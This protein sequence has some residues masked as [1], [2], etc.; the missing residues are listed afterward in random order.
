MEENRAGFT[1]ETQRAQRILDRLRK[2]CLGLRGAEEAT[3]WGYPTF[4]PG[5]NAFASVRETKGELCIV[6]KIG[7]RDQGLF[8]KDPRFLETP[9]IG[10]QGWVSLKAR[11]RLNW[12]EVRHLVTDSYRLV[13][14]EPQRRRSH[15]P[16][17]RT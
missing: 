10:K 9:Y 16:A 6:V 14:S 1:A 8:L 11:G 15:A 5:K 4:R 3:T 12:T 13:R 7:R 17:E 2:I